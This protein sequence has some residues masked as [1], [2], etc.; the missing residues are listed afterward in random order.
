MTIVEDSSCYNGVR[1]LKR[2]IGSGKGSGY[3]VAELLGLVVK[4][5]DSCLILL[6]Q[7]VERIFGNLTEL[8]E[9][10]VKLLG[11]L[12]DCIE[13]SGQYAGDSGDSQ[14]NV[15][16]AGII[17]EDLAEVSGYPRVC[18]LATIY[19]ENSPWGVCSI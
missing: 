4:V 18:P 7:D 10:S 2:M 17:F 5:M 3:L 1:L 12:D 8:H 11:D 19:V 16:Q 6:L 14:V 9:L 15:P 13:M